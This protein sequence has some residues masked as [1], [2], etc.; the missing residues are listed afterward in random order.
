MSYLDFI[1]LYRKDFELSQLQTKIEDEQALGT[2]LQKKI[3]E[4]QVKNKS[5]TWSKGDT[6]KQNY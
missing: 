2:Q 6:T 4:L 3:K 5:P 1:L